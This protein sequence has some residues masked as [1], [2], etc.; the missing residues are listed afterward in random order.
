MLLTLITISVNSI[1]TFLYYTSFVAFSELNVHLL[2]ILYSALVSLLEMQRYIL[3][4][5][6][7]WV[8]A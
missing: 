7:W 8:L 1:H 6:A 2:E 5:I 3:L 4:T